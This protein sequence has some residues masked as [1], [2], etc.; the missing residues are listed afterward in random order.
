[1]ME[2]KLKNGIKFN[3][4]GCFCGDV[5]AEQ[6]ITGGWTIY[7]KHTSTSGRDFCQYSVGNRLSVA[8]CSD[9]Y[10]HTHTA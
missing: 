4:F 2:V 7:L 10:T 1:M 6:T 3:A 8:L 5:R 9:S